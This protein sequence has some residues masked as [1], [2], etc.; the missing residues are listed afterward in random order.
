VRAA[1]R[2]KCSWFE[3]LARLEHFGAR[4]RGTSGKTNPPR[5]RSRHG[6]RRTEERPP[7]P[8]RP[9]PRRGRQEEHDARARQR[10]RRR[11][12]RRHH[13]R[14][15]HGSVP[16]GE[17]PRHGR[18]AQAGLGGHPRAR[19]ARAHQG[20]ARGPGAAHT[21]PT[22]AQDRAQGRR[23]TPPLHRARHARAASSRSCPASAPDAPQLELPVARLLARLIQRRPYFSIS[24]D[25]TRVHVNSALFE[26]SGDS[27]RIVTTDG[28]RL[29]KA[30]ESPGGPTSAQATM[31]IPLRARARAATPLPKRLKA[32]GRT[33]RRHLAER[34]R[35]PSS[36]SRRHAVLGEARRRDLPPLQAGH[37]A[38]TARTA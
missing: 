5:S 37:P 12:R 29:S 31:L 24:P 8:R 28:H 11:R 17:R 15:R 16:L 36:P 38:E 26:W 3:P 21:R 33:N 10:A 34:A 30:E 32:E 4:L 27:V 2:S 1:R 9:V 35:T 14:G 25:E 7:P 13:P 20:H 23:R 22:S 19:P 6:S 18:G